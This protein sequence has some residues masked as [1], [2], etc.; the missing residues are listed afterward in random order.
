MQRR[1]GT[2]AGLDPSVPA[3]IFKIG[4]Y[5]LHHGGVGAIRSLGRLGVP[6]Y[7]VTEDRFTPAAVSRYL[8][9]R[10]VWP[11]T[12]AE[13]PE[14][15]VEGLLARGRRLGRRTVLVPTDDEAA[16]LVAEHAEAL[17]GQFLLPG[18]PA[19][20][21]RRLADKAALFQLCQATGVPA[22]ASALPASVE[23]LL[24]RAAEMSYPVVLKNAAPWTRLQRPAVGNTTIVDDEAHL[25]AI[26]GGWP[27]MPAVL[28][29]A[30]LPAEGA[31]DWMTALYCDRTSACVVLGTGIKTRSWPPHAGVTTRAFTAPN[32]QLASM[33]ADLCRDIGFRGIADLDWRFDQADGQYKLLDFNPRIGAQFRLF[34]TDVGIDVVRALHLDL[35]GRAVPRGNQV[36]GRG[37]VVENL[38]LPAA[39][40]ERRSGSGHGPV[41]G[42]RRGTELAWLALDDPL[43]AVAAAARSAVPAAAVLRRLLR[44]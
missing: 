22:P 5:P 43:P 1:R 34:Q 29:Q 39:L 30:Y 12:G 28:V 4:R 11:T 18:V 44:R 25:R 32:P 14:E 15:L 42:S 33:A 16:V 2:A 36:D 37:L 13:S 19:D 17:S 9:G 35:T 31:E 26:A 40:A 8:T 7:A 3:L 24:A 41:A 38:D 21:P 27:V 6:V 10:F 23:E 20:L